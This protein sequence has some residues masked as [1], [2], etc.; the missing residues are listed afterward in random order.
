MRHNDYFPVGQCKI[1]KRPVLVPRAWTGLKKDGT[2]MPTPRY[3]TC[4]HEIK[5]VF[6]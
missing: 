6:N 1:C 3:K 5:G 4:R 2:Y